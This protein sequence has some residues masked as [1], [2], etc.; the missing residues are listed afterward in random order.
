MKKAFLTLLVALTVLFGM[1][2]L[3]RPALAL[4]C[5]NPQS[6]KEQI[7]CGACDASGTTD[8]KGN[9]TCDPGRSAGGVGSTIT[10]IINLLSAVG[11][12]AAVIVIVVAGLR[13]VTSGGK[14]E[15]VKN[16]KNGILYAIIGLVVIALAQLIVHF[17]LNQTTNAT[18]C[19]N[20][21]TSTGQKC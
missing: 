21:K 4:N 2:A 19:V 12:V 3:Q 10:T 11:G 17:V 13:Y 7:Q 9:P 20:G 1:S 5:D 18:D 16:A 15:G 6:A 8:A 14:E